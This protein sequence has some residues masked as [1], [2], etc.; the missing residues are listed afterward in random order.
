VIRRRPPVWASV[1]ALG[2]VAGVAV[3]VLG[4]VTPGF[5]VTR[6]FDPT[7]LRDG[8]RTVLIRDFGSGRVTEVQCPPEQRVAA[9]ERFVCT[10]R[11]DGAPAE[12][13]I[14]VQ[15]AAGRYTVGHP[16]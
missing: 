12:V 14:E 3:G 4:F 11:I 10:V 2:L 9:G 1:A 7:A 6:V 15:D 13:P 16:S 8:V 5:F